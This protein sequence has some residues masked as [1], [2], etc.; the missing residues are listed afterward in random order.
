MKI[1]GFKTFLVD[2]H[3]ANY[4]FVKLQ[5]DSGIEG[6]GESTVEWNEKAVVAA[7]EELGE[8]LIGKDPFATDY[9]ISLMHRNSYWRTGVVLRSALS[10]MEAAL[11]DIKGKALGVPV[12]ELLGGKHRDTVACYGNGW[13]AGAR[14]AAEFAA[15]AAEAV[16]MGFKGL[17]WDPFGAAYLEMDKLARNR[18]IEIVEAVR[19][20][21]GPDID[22]MIEVHGR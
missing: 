17:K 13:F 8:F 5:T 22:L 15:K 10:G 21:V 20:A 19:A 14:T 7:L 18:T 1:T 3:R 9:L 16:K 12:Y 6:L 4:I 11:L 2:A